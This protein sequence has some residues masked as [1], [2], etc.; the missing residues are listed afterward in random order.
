M[1]VGGGVSGSGEDS[2]EVQAAIAASLRASRGGQLSPLSTRQ[3]RRVQTE[4]KISSTEDADD[5]PELQ[6]AIRQS[7]DLYD[8]ER[9][10]GD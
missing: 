2:P 8:R 9:Q 5:D 3:R 7:L 10:T 1:P 6:N 4:P